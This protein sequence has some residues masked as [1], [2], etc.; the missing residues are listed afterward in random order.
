[1]AVLPTG[2]ERAPTRVM[3]FKEFE[4]AFN[5]AR[6]A[7][8]KTR[9]QAVGV[10]S[11]A[12]IERGIRTGKGAALTE[13]GKASFYSPEKLKLL[14]NMMQK[15]QRE[16]GGAKSAGAPVNQL[17]AMSTKVD[18]ERANSEIRNSRLY[19]VRGNMLKFAVKSSGKSGF[20]G[21]Y[22]VRIRLDQWDEALISGR[23][24]P[25]AAKLAAQGRASIDCNCGRHQY[26]FR[27]LA[28]VGG[29]AVTP[30]Q[31]KDF[32]K[33]RNPSLEGACCKHVLKVLQSLK[34]PT[35]QRVLAG[36]LERQAGAAGFGNVK[37]RFLNS[38]EQKQLKK[39]RSR[40]IKQD[41]AAKAYRDYLKAARGMKRKV[42][43]LTKEQQEIKVLRAKDKARQAQVK[44][45]QKEAETLRQQANISNMAA[46]LNKARADAVM[47]AA[48][49]GSDPMQANTRATSDFIS[50][51]SAENNLNAR[52]VEA[53]IKDNNL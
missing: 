39:G 14:R 36:E 26:W 49:S 21:H 16:F 44:K 8:N 35:V 48:M 5:V 27:Y 42:D 11:P 37:S 25:N 9:E 19:Q 47:K 38:E 33:I 52:D 32:P 50:K 45:A 18:I 28:G 12:A 2:T 1:M 20:D 29:F 34:T 23:K 41:T 51:Y 6:Q 53:L 17:I 46:S 40:E 4:R 7:N 22:Q 31:E 10:L 24:W 13:G 3:D 15:V 30:P 43:S